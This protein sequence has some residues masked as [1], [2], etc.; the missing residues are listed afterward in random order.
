MAKRKVEVI[1]CDFCG[2]QNIRPANGIV[3]SR[4]F[5]DQP[6][7]KIVCDVKFTGHIQPEGSA[8]SAITRDICIE[9]AHEALSDAMHESDMRR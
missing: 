6:G 8:T 2:R 9:C 1:D 7:Y 4:H 5:S 3:A